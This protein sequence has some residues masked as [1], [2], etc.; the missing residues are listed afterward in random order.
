[1]LDQN[2][3]LKFAENN[4]NQQSLF[5]QFHIASNVSVSDY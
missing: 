1:M 4:P 2:L 3:F 5:K